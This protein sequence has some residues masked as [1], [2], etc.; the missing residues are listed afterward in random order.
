MRI[1]LRRRRLEQASRSNFSL[2][3]RIKLSQAAALICRYPNSVDNEWLSTIGEE[4]TRTGCPA[5]WA[6]QAVTEKPLQS[7]SGSSVYTDLLAAGK[8][9]LQPAILEWQTL[10]VPSSA[11]APCLCLFFPRGCPSLAL[12]LSSAIPRSHWSFL[13]LTLCSL[14][15]SQ[16]ARALAQPKEEGED[17]A[18]DTPMVTALF[19]TPK[20]STWVSPEC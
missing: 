14:C 17:G 2:Q 18:Q 7:S 20:F 15:T 11:M 9:T 13:E 12:A 6:E 10:P 4:G 1:V 16:T 5:P 3:T 8:I 19:Q